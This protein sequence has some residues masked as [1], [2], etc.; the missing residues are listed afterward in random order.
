VAGA[1]TIAV[2]TR[3]VN[4]KPVREVSDA[5]FAKLCLT[6]RWTSKLWN[7]VPWG[8]SLIRQAELTRVDHGQPRLFILNL[9]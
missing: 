6:F 5:I 4:T 7:R 1:A 2:H 9:W 3:R 8:N